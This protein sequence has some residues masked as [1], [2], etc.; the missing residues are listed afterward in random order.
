VLVKSDRLSHLNAQRASGTDTQAK[1]SA[2]TQFFVQH[3]RLA[4]DNLD[5][6]FGAW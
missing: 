5:S 6:A 1:A 2:V 3:T 4:V